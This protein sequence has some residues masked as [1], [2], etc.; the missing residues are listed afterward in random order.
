M[1]PPAFDYHA[2]KTVGEALGLLGSWAVTPSCWPAA[3]AC[4][5]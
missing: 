1:I 5:R 2:P 3:T 4:C